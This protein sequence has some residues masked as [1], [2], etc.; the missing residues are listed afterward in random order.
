MAEQEL[1]RPESAWTTC[2]ATGKRGWATK[3]LAKRSGR[4]T[5]KGLSAY[6]CDRCDRWHIGHHAG[7]TRAD[8]KALHEGATDEPTWLTVEEVA[9]RLRP[10][11]TA[12]MSAVIERMARE[13]LVQAE[14]ALGI[15]L[16]HRDEV[17]RLMRAAHDRSQDERLKGMR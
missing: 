17:P 8:H 5:G 10:R 14:G 11:N 2:A 15:T 3:A 4:L 7:L 6:R 13:G 16:I 12:K 1:R 9:A